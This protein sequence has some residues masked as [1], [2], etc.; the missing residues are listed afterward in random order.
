MIKDVMTG[1][2]TGC[3]GTDSHKLLT[4]AFSALSELVSA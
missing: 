4:S 3:S 1:Y 2:L